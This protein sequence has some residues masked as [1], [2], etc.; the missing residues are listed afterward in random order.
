MTKNCR[1][2]VIL[3]VAVM[4]T[5]SISSYAFESQPQTKS[6]VVMR[7]GKMVNLFHSGTADVKKEICLD[8]VI[9]VYRETGNGRGG[10]HITSKEVGKVKVIGY[11]G[12]HYFKAEV[13]SGE[14]MAGDVAKKDSAWC[15]VRQAQYNK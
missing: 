1:I 7:V 15:L 9:Q 10:L 11:E 12:E 6:K 2:L 8:D 4:A 14:I 5:A 13:V 3:T